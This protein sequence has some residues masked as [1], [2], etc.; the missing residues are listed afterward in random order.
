MVADTIFFSPSKCISVLKISIFVL[1]F[2]LIFGNIIVQIENL[3]QTI[4]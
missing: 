3:L 1:D 2:Y 4:N